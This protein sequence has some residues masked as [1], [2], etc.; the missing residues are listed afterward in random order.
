MNHLNTTAGAVGTT[1]TATA[2][3]QHASGVTTGE[4]YACS[5]CASMWSYQ[6]VRNTGR[7]PA[8]GNGLQRFVDPAQ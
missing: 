1:P 3:Q 5:A 4:T 6:T 7:C 8:C 2:A